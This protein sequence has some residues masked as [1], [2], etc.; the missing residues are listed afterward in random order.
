[1][2]AHTHSSITRVQ[3]ER[4]VL[5][6]VTKDGTIIDMWFNRATKVIET[7]YPNG[8]TDCGGPF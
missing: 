6:G 1:M 7:A 5:S 8:R 4:V 3:G 2:D